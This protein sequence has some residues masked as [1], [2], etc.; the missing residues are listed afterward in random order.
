MNKPVSD[1]DTFYDSQ[2]ISFQISKFFNCKNARFFISYVPFFHRE[3]SSDVRIR[4]KHHDMRSQKA[5]IFIS[6]EVILIISSHCFL[7][8]QYHLKLEA[9][10]LDVGLS[11]ILFAFSFLLSVSLLA[12]RVSQDTDAVLR[13]EAVGT[14]WSFA[15]RGCS[16]YSDS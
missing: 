2:G 12:L 16:P 10:T 9:L 6:G 14:S 15:G 5:L 8:W 11:N 4:T 13:H 1:L 7:G 3:C